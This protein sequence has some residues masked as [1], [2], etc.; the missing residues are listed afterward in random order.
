VIGELAALIAIGVATP[1]IVLGSSVRDG[2]P[3]AIVV[4][5]P[6]PKYPPAALR[7]HREGAAFLKLHVAADGRVD[8]ASAFAGHDGFREPALAAM[9]RW[10]YQPVSVSGKRIARTVYAQAYFRL[11]LDP[12]E[13]LG[14]TTSAFAVRLG[15]DRKQNMQELFQFDP[16]RSRL[17][18]TPELKARLIQLIS[19][20][21][22]VPV[23][24]SQDAYHG[25]WGV[26]F[27]LPDRGV[28]LLVSNS[29]RKL[30]FLDEGRVWSSEDQRI[31]AEITRELEGL[32]AR[33]RPRP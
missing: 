26:S 24:Q 14:K 4:Y 30:W 2:E 33:Q 23:S 20:S 3:P 21:G 22:M 6:Q 17:G 16:I 10:K 19:T 12:A 29:Q 7:S 15:A 25:D 5:Q 31:V 18:M 28:A 13:L 11:D 9:R 1:R 8:S 32:M 27:E